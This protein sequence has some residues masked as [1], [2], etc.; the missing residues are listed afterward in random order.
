MKKLLIM[1][2]ITGLSVLPCVAKAQ[3]RLG[4]GAMG[5]I[6]GGLGRR[7]G[8]FGRGWCR[9]LFGGAV[10]CVELGP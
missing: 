7:S 4:D 3:E 5:G 6:G 1:A 8:W 2:A 9:W 10:N